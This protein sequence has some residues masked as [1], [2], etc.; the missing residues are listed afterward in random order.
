MGLFDWMTKKT[1]G[2]KKSPIER[3]GH[4]IVVVSDV[5]LKDYTPLTDF[6]E[7]VSLGQIREGQTDYARMAIAIGGYDSDPRP[8]WDIPEVTA[9]YRDLHTAHPYMPMFLSP[10]SIQVYFRVLQPIAQSILPEEFASNQD[11]V[12]LLLHVFAARNK[13][14]AEALGGDDERLQDVLKAADAMVTQAVVK[15]SKGIDEPF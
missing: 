15:L 7:S 14:F 12:G 2:S 9:W 11:L 10:G 8:L 6:I 1:E 13:Y 4:S 3:I 5:S